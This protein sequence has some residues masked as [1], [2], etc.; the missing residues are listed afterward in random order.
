MSKKIQK[1]VVKETPKRDVGD[2]LL[3][4]R[5]NEIAGHLHD[6]SL[7]LYEDQDQAGAAEVQNLTQGVNHLLD[8][9][10]FKLEGYAKQLDPEQGGAE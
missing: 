4:S 10:A 2:Y 8:H 1:P 6:M 9:Y 5:L 3:A 7:M